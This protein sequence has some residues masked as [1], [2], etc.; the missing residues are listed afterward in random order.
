VSSSAA[1]VV[2]VVFGAVAI[3]TLVLRMMR[4]E[5]KRGNERPT[6]EE[7]AAQIWCRP[8]N[9]TRVMDVELCRSI[10]AALHDREGTSPQVKP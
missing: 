10:A 1:F 2:G 9:A 4:A 5:I 3:A 7:F 6:A 8:E